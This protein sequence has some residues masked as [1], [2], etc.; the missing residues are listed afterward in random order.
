MIL[1]IQCY[2][3]NLN[4]CQNYHFWNFQKLVKYFFTKALSCVLI[5]SVL[6][7]QV[8]KYINFHPHWFV[9]FLG[10][11]SSLFLFQ[12]L[13]QIRLIGCSRR[14]NQ[15]KNYLIR[16]LK[17]MNH[18]HSC[19]SYKYRFL[20]PTS[21]EPIAPYLFVNFRILS[22]IKVVTLQSLFLI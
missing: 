17:K 2:L 14:Q 18:C 20:T 3:L 13:R 10:L 11:L 15:K 22:L 5:Q 8:S 7:K 16:R 9:L 6:Q 21:F 12:S 19:C 1:Q 4:S